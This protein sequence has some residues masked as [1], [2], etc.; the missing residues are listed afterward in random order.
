MKTVDVRISQE[1]RNLLASVVGKQFTKYRCDKIMFRP[2]VYQALGAFF[3]GLILSVEN[4]A[5]PLDYYGAIEDVGVMRVR[6]VSPDN[7]VSRIVDGQQIDTPV[8]QVVRDIKVIDD[9]HY[10]EKDSETLYKFSYTKAIVFVL[11]DRQV[12]FEKD[13]WFSEDILIYR[14]AE[15]ESKIMDVDSEIEESDQYSFRTERTVSNLGSSL[16]L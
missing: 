14:G 7:V 6:Q 10:M 1:E 11:P 9:T 4:E 15:A 16:N 2:A 5:Q 12:V 13:I 8:N 3:D